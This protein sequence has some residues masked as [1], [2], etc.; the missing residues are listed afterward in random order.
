MPPVGFEPK[1]SAGER[2]AAAHLLRS[3]TKFNENPSSGSRLVSCADCLEIWEPQPSGTLRACTGNAFF[4][5]Q[6][7]LISS[8]CSKDK[9]ISLPHTKPRSTLHSS[10]FIQLQTA[11]LRLIVRS[12]LDVPTFATSRLHTCH[13]A[14]APSGGR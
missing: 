12:W 3:D 6:S 8:L 4:C 9:R 1:V 7:F 2:P 11:V 13:H 10:L 5:F 14:R